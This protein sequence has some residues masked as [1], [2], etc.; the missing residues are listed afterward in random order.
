MLYFLVLAFL[1]LFNIFILLGNFGERIL[2][3]SLNGLLD[4][5]FNVIS[6]FIL[7]EIVEAVIYA[8]NV[9]FFPSLNIERHIK[10]F[11]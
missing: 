1:F 4:L 5:I 6:Y 7:D 11:H 8:I 2:D 10:L 3:E 9:N